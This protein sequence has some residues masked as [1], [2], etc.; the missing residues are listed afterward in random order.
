MVF[1]ASLPGR[2]AGSKHPLDGPA[3]VEFRVLEDLGG[4]GRDVGRPLG[5]ARLKALT[6]GVPSIGG[7]FGELFGHHLPG[8]F[9]E[10]DI[11]GLDGRYDSVGDV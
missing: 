1:A 10:R 3:T 7:I 2:A 9:H 6:F 5:I 8:E 11:P 4:D